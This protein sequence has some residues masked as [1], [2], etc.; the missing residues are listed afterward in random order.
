MANE[1]RVM[2][3]VDERGLTIPK[4]WLNDIEEVEIRKERNVILILPIEPTDPILKLGAEP[5]SCDVDDASENHDRYLTLAGPRQGDGFFS[6]PSVINL[7]FVGL[8]HSFTRRLQQ[9][10]Q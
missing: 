6:V 4:Q 9:L 8:R 1:K 7:G 5:V 10:L 2:R 3:K